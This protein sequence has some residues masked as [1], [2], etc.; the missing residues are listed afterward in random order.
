MTRCLSALGLAQI[1]YRKRVGHHRAANIQ[2]TSN[3]KATSFGRMFCGIFPW[4]LFLNSQNIP[5]NALEN[6]LD[7]YTDLQHLAPHVAAEFPHPARHSRSLGPTQSAS[8]SSASRPHLSKQRNL[9]TSGLLVEY[10]GYNW[11]NGLTRR[12][13]C[14]LPSP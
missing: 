8:H 4:S 13:G 11:E 3:P 9:V 1:Y 7:N 5:F 12:R 10:E 6:V 2:F 14:I